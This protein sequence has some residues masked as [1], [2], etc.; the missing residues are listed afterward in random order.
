MPAGSLEA[1]ER[2]FQTTGGQHRGYIIPQAVTHSLVLLKM[3]RMIARNM[4]SWLELSISRHCCIYLVVYIISMMH[5][6]ANSNYEYLLYSKYFNL[7]FLRLPNFLT[8]IRYYL[9]LVSLFNLSRNSGHFVF[10]CP[11]CQ[12]QDGTFHNPYLFPWL[13][14]CATRHVRYPSRVAVSTT[15]H[16]S[17]ATASAFVPSPIRGNV[18]ILINILK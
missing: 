5:G 16:T 17:R 2:R 12:A 10:S 9:S 3:G 4:L 6:Q 1:E 11:M 13:T 7:M 14:D 18:T 8:F 15:W